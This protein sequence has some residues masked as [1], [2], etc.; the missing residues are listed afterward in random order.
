MIVLR[1]AGTRGAPVRWWGSDAVNY[2]RGRPR[3]GAHNARALDQ[4]ALRTGRY[5]EPEAP[6]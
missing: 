4:I 1:L 2:R 6:R 5:V 3:R